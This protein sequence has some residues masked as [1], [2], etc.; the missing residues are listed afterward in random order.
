MTSAKLIRVLVTLLLTAFSFSPSFA[1]VWHVDGDVAFS[2]DGTSWETAFRRIQEGID[3]ASDGDTVIVAPGTYAEEVKIEAKGVTLRSSNPP[4]AQVVAMTII[5]GTARYGSAVDIRGTAA[6]KAIL[7]GFTITGSRYSGVRCGS[8]AVIK[9]CV[10]TDNTTSYAGGGIYCSCIDASVSIISCRISNNSTRSPATRGGG[11]YVS[12][13]CSAVIENNIIVDNQALHG[14]GIY[15]D[16]ES[17]EVTNNTIV[18]NT[19]A[20]VDGPVIVRN[21]I[22]WNNNPDLRRAIA[23]YCCTQTG[24][25]GET[26]F[27]YF[28]HFADAEKGDFRLQPWSPCIDAGDPES[29]FSLEPQPNGG[30]VNVGAYGNTAEA[31]IRSADTDVDGL[32][33][34]WEIFHFGNIAEEGSGDADSDGITNHGE[35]LYDWDPLVPAPERVVNLS[36]GRYLQEIHAAIMEAYDGDEI[37]VLPGTHRKGFSFSG[38][39]VTVR[40]LDPASPD[41]VASTIIRTSSGPAVKFEWGEGTDTIL[42]GLTVESGSDC[43]I[44]CENSSPLI[45]NNVITCATGNGISSEGGS[46]EIRDNT[47]TACSSPIACDESS[48]LIIGNNIVDNDGAVRCYLAFPTIMSN[49]IARNQQGA[50]WFTGTGGCGSPGRGF[51]RIIGNTVVDNQGTGIDCAGT[52]VVEGNFILRNS[53]LTDAGGID[54]VGR[55]IWITGNL[56]AENVGK[57]GGISAA[58]AVIANNTIVNNRS[59]RPGDQGGEETESVGIKAD[60]RADITNCIVWGHDVDLAGCRASYSYF[61]GATGPKG[62]GDIRQDPMFVDPADGD[63]HLLPTSPCIAAGWPRP[64]MPQFDIDLEPFPFNRRPDIGADQFTD[65][66]GDLLPDYWEIR[67]FGTTDAAPEGDPDNDALT[68]LGELL[69]RSGWNIPDTDG[70]GLLDGD[71]VHSWQ[72]DPT[73]PDT[74]GDGLGDGEE[75]LVYSTLPTNPDSDGD[76]LDDELE[77]HQL[78]TDPNAVDTDSDNM[79]DRWEF[80]HQLDPNSS[81]GHNGALGDPD[82]DDLTNIDELSEGTDPQNPDT[83]SDGLTDGEE[84]RLYLTIPTDPDTDGDGLNDGFEVH[85]LETDPNDTDTDGDGMPDDW[86]FTH[87]LSPTAAEGEDGPSGDP[88]NDGLTNA[89]ELQLGTHPQDSDTDSDGMP[90]DWE[91]SHQ[92]SPTSSEELHGALGDPDADDLANINEFNQGTDPQKPDTDSDGLTDGEEV[93][94]YSTLP[95]IPDTDGDGLNDGFEV[96]ELK[97]DPN[98]IDTDGDTMPDDWELRHQLSPTSSQSQDG[99][100]GDPDADD[101]ANINEFNQGTDPQNPDTDSDGLTDGEEVNFY[102]TL[103]KIPD[104]DGDG[105]NDGVEVHEFKTDPND[106]DTD[107]DGVS[108]KEEVSVGTDPLDPL[109]QFPFPTIR[110]EEG[111]REFSITWSAAPGRSYRVHFSPHLFF[112]KSNLGPIVAEAPTVSVRIANEPSLRRYFFRV[113]LLP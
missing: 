99:S 82:S 112:W 79:P 6:E 72:A 66:D 85:D 70:D 80:I 32:P 83:D 49:Y 3:A 14:A 48:P 8:W 91:L 57:P 37:I 43:A 68:N 4:N 28:P 71:E 69:N 108:D 101:L 67:E 98:D 56:V 75:V 12:S 84:V 89:E 90:D 65:S 55:S 88:D 104:T 77:V 19:G 20:G 100:L 30:R 107:D 11:I 58:E 110:L 63:Y 16:S 78:K 61:A 106:I 86:E 9:R 17:V 29:D 50:I 22:L 39:A 97:T 18:G 74:D 111:G 105:L 26:N 24:C 27:S 21:C 81:E 15:S 76:G 5:Q 45:R 102:S 46:P 59:P 103:P 94:S 96:H 7:D 113:E 95:T 54:C 53:S 34:D 41:V 42:A 2:G 47:I 87:E 44:F 51:A 64:E 92:L 31:T 35:Y 62:V 52:S 73:N 60:S 33:D 40:S 38:R 109:S 13:S 1:A 10:I 23:F 25:P 36:S 93:N